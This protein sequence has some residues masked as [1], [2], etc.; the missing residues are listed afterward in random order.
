MLRGVFIAICISI[1]FPS[2]SQ[3]DSLKS[4]AALIKLDTVKAECY[5]KIAKSYYNNEGLLDSSLLYYEKAARIYKKNNLPSKLAKAL[6]GKALMYR[7]KGAYKEGLDNCLQAL[8]I[9]EN[10]KDTVQITASLNGIA[11]INQIQKNFDK[12]F[13]YYKKCEDIHLLTNNNAGLASTY[14]NLGL[15]FSDKNEPD[16]SYEYFLKSLKYNEENKNERG[17][18]T[19]CENIGLHFLNFK[20]NPE[21]A[22]EHFKRSIAIWRGMNDVNSVAITLDYIVTA[23]FEQK[24]Y[25]ECL[26]STKLSLALATQAGS[27][28]SLKQAHE[29]LYLIYEKLHD[30]GSA[31]NHYKQFISLR[32]SLNNNDQLR[33]I[34][35]M[36]MTY[37]FDKQREVDKL[38]QELKQKELSDEISR[39]NSIILFFI[40]TLILVLVGSVLIWR[41]Y[42]INKSAKEKIAFQHLLLEEQNKSILDSIKYA[43]HIQEAI[44]PSEELVKSLLNE[45][46]IFYKPKDIVSGDFYWVEEKNDKIYLAVVDCTGHGVPGAFISI[47]G[48]NGLNEAVNNL[49]NPT[50]AQ[51]LDFLNAYVNKSMN[52]TIENSAVRDGMDIALCIIDKKRNTIQY[53]GA[54]NPLLV[55]RYSDAV[56]EQN[57]SLDSVVIDSRLEEYKADK[58]PIGNFIGDVCRPFSS[59]E[60]NYQKGDMLYLFSDGYSDQFGGPKR[61]KFKRSQLK[62]LL[63][64]IASY[65]IQKQRQVIEQAF[66]EWK[67]NIEQIDDVCVFGVKM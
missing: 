8:S 2:F 42:R 52:Q 30:S 25:K 44:L 36:Q 47:V 43:K 13:E 19:A 67:G 12:A 65:P 49:Q 7:E 50:S 56:K 1:I 10:V 66:D 16:K 39:Q 3:I 41:S 51:M 38:K 59:V 24:K 32:D 54:N 62:K 46:F 22:M 33:E 11:I 21:K 63:Y 17:V 40:I 60:V 26:D 15:L 48:R 58:Q 4:Y 45:S 5:I 27:I 6:N 28:F 53:S 57:I 35:E 18:A 31:L 37:E 20:N 14:N 64:S 61:K 23:M 9:A 34:T 29:K 55:V